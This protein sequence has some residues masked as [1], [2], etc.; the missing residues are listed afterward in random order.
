MMIVNLKVMIDKSVFATVDY[1][2]YIVNRIH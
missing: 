2:I 1:R